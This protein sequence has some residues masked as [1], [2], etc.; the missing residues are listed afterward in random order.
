VFSRSVQIEKHIQEK[1]AAFLSAF[2]TI[3]ASETGIQ[4]NQN[5][6]ML[7]I[8]KNDGMT[9]KYIVCNLLLLQS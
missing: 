6:I 4:K 8:W 1:K 7:G 3:F 5:T 2:I 9:Y